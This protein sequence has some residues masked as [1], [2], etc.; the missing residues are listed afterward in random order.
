L[1]NFGDKEDWH[2]LM[3]NGE[4]LL[5]RIEN[6]GVEVSIPV[7]FKFEKMLDALKHSEATKRKTVI[8]LS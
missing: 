8:R 3:Q 4:A 6:G 5:E 7:T 2:A 1:H